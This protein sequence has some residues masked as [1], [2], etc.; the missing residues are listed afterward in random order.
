MMYAD[1]Q[2]GSPGKLRGSRRVVGA[3]SARGC[4][5]VPTPVAKLE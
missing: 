5:Y 2:P 1:R 4:S 3:C